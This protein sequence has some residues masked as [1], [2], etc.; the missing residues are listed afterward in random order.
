MFLGVPSAHVTRDLFGA[1]FSDAL[2]GLPGR[3]VDRRPAPFGVASL[4]RLLLVLEEGR[5][6]NQGILSFGTEHPSWP[7]SDQLQNFGPSL[8][9]KR[10]GGQRSDTSFTRPSWPGPLL[11]V[12]H[13]TE[14]V[15]ASMTQLQN[16]WLGNDFTF[17]LIKVM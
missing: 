2:D 12:T 11:T 10:P 17:C 7:N 16:L 8:T 14:G 4:R 13:R 1:C 15:T 6:I 9:C 3:P 5:M